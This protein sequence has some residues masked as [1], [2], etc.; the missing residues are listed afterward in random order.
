MK[1]PFYL[2]KKSPNIQM[3]GGDE[4]SND[5]PKENNAPFLKHANRQNISTV[6]I[7]LPKR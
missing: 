7:I 5:N 2:E 3:T 4:M 6:T 1:Y